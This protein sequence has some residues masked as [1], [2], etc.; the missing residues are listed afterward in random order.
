M[1]LKY[2][3]LQIVTQNVRISLCTSIHTKGQPF[4]MTMMTGPFVISMMRDSVRFKW[5]LHGSVFP[6]LLHLILTWWLSSI[7]NNSL[8]PC[9]YMSLASS[10]TS[11][12]YRA[13]TIGQAL[14]CKY[15][16]SVNPLN[17]TTPLWVQTIITPILLMRTQELRS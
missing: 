8:P 1:C 14:F 15:F 6:S 11:H 16:T 7:N 12:T 13:I 3:Y 4:V 10:T 9:I 17:Q 2:H 5:L